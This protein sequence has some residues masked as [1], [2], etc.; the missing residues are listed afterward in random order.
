MLDPS[1]N[2]EAPL[3]MATVPLSDPARSIMLNLANLTS[4]DTAVVRDFCFR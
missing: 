1:L 3:V 4:A 2:L